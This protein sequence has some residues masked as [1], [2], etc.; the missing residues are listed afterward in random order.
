MN[1]SVCRG[2]LSPYLE[3]ELSPEQ[4][5][6][7]EQHLSAC[8]ACTTELKAL[9]EM[10]K[11]LKELPEP[12]APSEFRQKVWQR[13][14]AA[15]P[16][17]R[18]RQRVL[19][20]WYFKV[21]AGAL[22]TAAVVLLAVQVT[23]HTAPALNKQMVT[24][25]ELPPALQQGPEWDELK[26]RLPPAKS[27]FPTPLVEKDGSTRLKAAPPASEVA[28]RRKLA[29]KLQ[30]LPVSPGASAPALEMAQRNESE[31][32]DRA[33][34]QDASTVNA[35]RTDTS[36]AYTVIAGQAHV[37]AS[38][39]GNP[40]VASTHPSR[41]QS[42]IAPY[43]YDTTARISQAQTGASTNPTMDLSTAEQLLAVQDVRRR[44]V[45]SDRLQMPASSARAPAVQVGPL[46]PGQLPEPIRPPL[47]AARTHLR[48]KVRDINSAHQAILHLIAE[49]PMQEVQTPFPI[50]HHELL[51][52]PE[53]VD[54]FL[55]GLQVLGKLEHVEEQGPEG[56]TSGQRL[57]VLDLVPSSTP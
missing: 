40:P 20:P 51:M 15:S 6:A 16:W 7:V 53:R 44:D 50:I 46:L 29:Q 32:A 22:A 24:Q 9:Q 11:G 12:M 1:C 45:A 39:S 18:F 23:R 38:L 27:Q 49:I 34:G 57:I 19:E 3:E 8:A 56:E 14:E 28:G 42:G 52:E 4:R 10:V 5:G 31:S 26:K 33:V 54:L 21:P 47:P 43:K 37:A 17:V 2:Q 25:E 13:I 48:L 36:D 35:S 41:T 55:D 30:V